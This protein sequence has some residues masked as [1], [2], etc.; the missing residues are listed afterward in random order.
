MKAAVVAIACALLVAGC[1]SAS[2]DTSTTTSTTPAETHANTEAEG[3]TVVT[4]ATAETETTPPP[5]NS[6]CLS[7]AEV[8]QEVNKIA[9][10]AEASQGEVEAKQDAIRKVRERAC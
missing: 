8:E 10:G 9:S 1:G 6:G 7:P 4:E 2:K 3:G 5:A